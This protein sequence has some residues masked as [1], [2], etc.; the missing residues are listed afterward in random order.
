MPRAPL[1]PFSV[2]LDEIEVLGRLDSINLFAMTHVP[3]E[4]RRKVEQ[5]CVSNP[6]VRIWPR[7]ARI[8]Q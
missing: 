8:C 2:V 4:A 7:P 6:D 3:T 5:I 1:H